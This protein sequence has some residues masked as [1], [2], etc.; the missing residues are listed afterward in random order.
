[1]LDSDLETVRAHLGLGPKSRVLVVNT[2]GNTDPS[3]YNR[4]IGST[5]NASNQRAER[6]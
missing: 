5:L 2:E 6:A 4:A 1:M 3:V